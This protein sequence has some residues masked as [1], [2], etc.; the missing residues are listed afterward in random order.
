MCLFVRP[1]Q[2]AVSNGKVISAYDMYGHRQ[3]GQTECPGN[4]YYVTIQSY[5]DWVRG[6]GGGG[7]EV[8]GRGVRERG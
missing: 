6:G 5:P 7:G 3:A 1:F 4:T 2:C 8:L